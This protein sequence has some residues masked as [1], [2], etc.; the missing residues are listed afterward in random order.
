MS[1][2]YYCTLIFDNLVMFRNKL[3]EIKPQTEGIN[4]YK[5][6]KK[7]KNV[8]KFFWGSQICQKITLAMFFD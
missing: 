4:A 5:W 7:L 8:A 2:C 6:A 3:F 1:Q